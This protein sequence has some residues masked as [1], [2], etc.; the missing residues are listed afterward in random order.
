MDVA[1]LFS[2]SCPDVPP[3]GTPTCGH[4]PHLTPLQ[5][6]G[7]DP[8][9]SWP[10]GQSCPLLPLLCSRSRVQ[11]CVRVV[12]RCWAR[13]QTMLPLLPV[14]LGGKVQFLTLLA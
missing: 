14:V 9:L 7:G 1:P 4:S 11:V 6:P 12:G 5:I 2:T 3:K 8:Q 13:L 10:N